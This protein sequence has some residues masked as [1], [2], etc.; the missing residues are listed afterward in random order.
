M[1]ATASPSHATQAGQMYIPAHFRN[2]RRD[3]LLEVMRTYDFA[4]LVSN[5]AGLPFATHLPVLV[6]EDGERLAI[7]AHVAAANPHWQALQEDPRALI[8][9]LG[10]HTY[11]SPS[12]YR[13]FE[14]VPTWN[15]IAVHATCE[16]R[17]IADAKGKLDIL[18]RLIQRHDPGFAERFSQFQD[19]T[20]EQ[21]LRAI[22]GLEFRVD[23]LEGKFKLGQHRLADDRPEN[24]QEHEQ[25][26]EDRQALAQ[27]MKRLGYWK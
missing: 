12:A 3:D 26:G 27:W 11:V 17:I 10:P 2:D 8:I 7:D 6:R 15:Y 13:S 18:D 22:V 19:A 21:L 5:R 9:F 14:R 23:S 4:T 1:P 20:R 24:Q 25:G 16:A